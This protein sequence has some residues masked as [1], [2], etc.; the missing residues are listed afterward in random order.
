MIALALLFVLSG[1]AGLIY[2]SVW[3]RYIS[4]LVGHSAYAQVIVLVIFLGG[5]AIGSIVVGK[6][7]DRIRSPLLWY[8]IVEA[9]IAII[10]VGFHGAFV[11]VTDMAYESWLPSLSPGAAVTSATWILAAL[12]IL[13]Q[14]ILLGATFPL[15]TA[16]ALR[17]RPKGTGASIGLLYFANSFGA[18]IGALVSGFTLVASFGLDGTLRAAAVLNFIVAAGVIAGFVRPGRD[19]L[20]RKQTP[21][22]TKAE[23]WRTLTRAERVLLAVSFATAFSSFLYEIAWTRMLSMVNGSATHSFELMLS[24]FIFGLAVGALWISRYADASDDPMRLL[25]RLQWAMGLAA[26]ATLPLYL[27]SFDWTASLLGAIRDT[28]SGYKLYSVA[29]YAISLSIMLPATFFAGT[30]LPLITK[31]LLGSGSGERVIG[32]VYG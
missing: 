20:G 10:A 4:L 24:A 8:A 16:G 2:E 5:M 22:S 28:E 1:A 26:I 6:W 32:A 27:W 19:G 23:G 31:I 9:I 11:A 7:S 21:D 15:M 13:P 14:S 30:T 12:L 29:R 25:A 3:A 18:A 17:R